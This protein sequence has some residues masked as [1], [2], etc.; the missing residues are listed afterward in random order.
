MRTVVLRMRLYLWP[1]IIMNA[2]AM[3]EPTYRL[4]ALFAGA[5]LCL[6]A[7]FGFIIN[8]LWDRAVDQANDRERLQHLRRPAR[9]GMLAFALSLVALAFSFAARAGEFA[10]PL[11][12]GIATTLVL[13]TVALRRVLLVANVV[14]AAVS[15]S[16]LWVPLVL[17]E[18]S[19][20]AFR[21]GVLAAVFV[22]LVG[23]E[24]VLDAKDEVGDRIA[25]RR[26]FPTVVGQPASV[27]L[28]MVL[29]ASAGAG[30]IMTVVAFSRADDLLQYLVLC[31]MALAIPG[32]LMGTLR[33]LRQQQAFQP[34]IVASGV[35]MLIIPLLIAIQ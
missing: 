11:A 30:Q 15:S 23:R 14:A 8:D 2:V 35:A 9:V 34:F 18:S 17:F 13:Y 12:V 20:S 21:I 16:P 4:R 33:R 10:I 6:L 26:T 5:C 28:A 3:T 25:G 1:A 27:R 7:S 24:I 19:M 32:L 22:L 31:G 29:F